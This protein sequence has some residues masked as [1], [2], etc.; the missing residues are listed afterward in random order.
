MGK[1]LECSLGLLKHVLMVYCSCRSSKSEGYCS[2]CYKS[3]R[4]EEPAVSIAPARVEPEPVELNQPLEEQPQQLNRSRCY[5]CNKKVGH[6]G[7]ECKCKYIFCG[8]H[9]YHN[10]HNCTV[11]YHHSAKDHLRQN[12]LPVIAPK[13]DKI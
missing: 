11:D 12:N 5:K 8:N 1:L 2:L 3:V 7:F 6:L 4:P 13:M 10:E 9:R